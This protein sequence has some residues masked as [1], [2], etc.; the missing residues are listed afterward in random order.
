MYSLSRNWRNRFYSLSNFLA[1]PPI[2]TKLYLA[3]ARNIN[4]PNPAQYQALPSK[5]TLP[6]VINVLTIWRCKYI[7]QSNQVSV[8]KFPHARECILSLY[9]VLRVTSLF[10]SF[11]TS[12]L[13]GR[14]TPYSIFSSGEPSIRAIAFWVSFF[15]I[16]LQWD[17][18]RRNVWSRNLIW[19]LWPLSHTLHMML[20]ICYMDCI[21]AQGDHS[22]VWL[23]PFPRVRYK[24]ASLSVSKLR[25][26]DMNELIS[27]IFPCRSSDIVF[28]RTRVSWDNSRR[29]LRRRRSERGSNTQLL[30]FSVHWMQGISLEYW[31]F[32]AICLAKLASLSNLVSL[33]STLL[34]R[35]R[36]P[37]LFFSL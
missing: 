23:Y 5:N 19:K 4:L 25:I 36:Y 26:A 14:A 10:P 30:P 24:I 7:W 11:F 2:C 34:T 31:K 12:S 33:L 21:Y 22:K 8:A 3:W 18:L 35:Y 15:Y 28:P 20:F 1:P 27:L 37:S 29:W 9:E 32:L 13:R 6:C 17:S 16:A